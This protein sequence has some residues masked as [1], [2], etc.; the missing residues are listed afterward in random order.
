MNFHPE[1]ISE[2]DSTNAEL[3]RRVRAGEAP[4]DGLILAARHQTAG[5]G[6]QARRWETDA[7]KTLTASLFLSADIPLSKTPSLTFALALAI[8]QFLSDS[9]ISASLKWPND[10]LVGGKKIAGILTQNAQPGVI[11]GFGLNLNVSVEKLEQIDQPATSYLA[12]RGNSLAPEVA[13]ESLCP[14]FDTWLE[15]VQTDGFSGIREAYT[16]ACGGVG[17]K[18]RVR[19]NDEYQH[20]TLAGFG[21][22]GEL[23]LSKNGETHPV[24]SGDLILGE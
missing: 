18:V 24:W 21:E 12:E 6:R 16:R 1:W 5:R 7:G 19:E 4:R 22:H 13:L 2:T 11:I 23:L 14:Y 10:L 3:L 17:T 15:R 9:Q 8:R 20:G